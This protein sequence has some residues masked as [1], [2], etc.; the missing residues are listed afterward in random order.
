[1]MRLAVILSDDS[2]VAAPETPNNMDVSRSEGAEGKAPNGG[3]QHGNSVP[4]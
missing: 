3:R 4:R 1:M 2:P